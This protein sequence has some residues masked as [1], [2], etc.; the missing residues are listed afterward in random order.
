[1]VVLVV[2]FFESEF[3]TGGCSGV[4]GVSMKIFYTYRKDLYSSVVIFVVVVLG[5]GG[6]KKMYSFVRPNR[7]T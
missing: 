3:V 5:K 4:V 1:M 6:F 2:R 7:A